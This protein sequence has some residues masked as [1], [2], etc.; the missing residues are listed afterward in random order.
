VYGRDEGVSIRGAI[1]MHNGAFLTREEKMK[2]T[3]EAA[4]LADMIALPGD[5]PNVSPDKI[6][7]MKVGVTI[8]GGQSALRA[9]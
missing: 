9:G 1:T 2:G 6:S 3:L 4:K 8:V 7:N 5:L